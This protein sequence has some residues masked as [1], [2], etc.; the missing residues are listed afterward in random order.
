M[1]VAPEPEKIAGADSESLTQGFLRRGT[2]SALGHIVGRAARQAGDRG[3]QPE[4]R[5]E[6]QCDFAIANCE[7]AAVGGY[8]SNPANL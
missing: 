7:D 1:K 6:T 4:L 8:G 5:A 3:A 2:G